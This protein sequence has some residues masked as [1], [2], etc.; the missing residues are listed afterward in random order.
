MFAAL[1]NDLQAWEF[2]FKELL[3]SYIELAEEFMNDHKIRYRNCDNPSSGSIHVLAK[4]ACALVRRDICPKVRLRSNK[5]FYRADGR[6]IRRRNVT[7]CYNEDLNVLPDDPPE[8]PDASP[9]VPVAS[10]STVVTPSR[11]QSISSSQVLPQDNATT[12]R[13]EE[14]IIEEYKDKVKKYAT[15]YSVDHASNWFGY[16]ELGK[17]S[18]IVFFF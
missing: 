6:V 8:D 4:Y 18:S 14:S 9:Q 12:Q 10:I 13:T 11:V 15:A 5:K 7:S 16:D 3:H 1:V 17:V 2:K